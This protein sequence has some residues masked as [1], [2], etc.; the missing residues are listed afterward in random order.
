M[1]TDFKKRFKHNSWLNPPWA[2]ITAYRGSIAHGMYVPQSDP[3]SIDDKDVMA[4]V[5]PDQTH[6]FGLTTFGSKGTME[7]KE[8]EWDIVV[9]ELRKFVGLLVK[10]NPNVITMLWLE[11]QDYIN[12]TEAGEVLIK[13]R[14]LFSTRQ[15]FHSF[16]GYAKGQLHR[17]THMAFEGYMGEKR[18]RLVKQFGY[19]TK[20]AA[21][22]IRLLRMSIEFLTEGRMYVKRKDAQELLA[23][24]R[25]EWSL[26]KVKEE[27]TRLFALSEEAYVRSPLPDRPDM[28]MV[29][30]ICT[31]AAKKALGFKL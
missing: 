15:A 26:E 19:D 31:L 25:G 5:V 28:D 22:L 30:G 12:V 1:A 14:D 20:N 21:H 27:S 13:N 6:Y 16:S 24:K 23:I 18:K 17:M 4:I 8:D 2:I 29:N 10:A 7:I 11:D 3:N 9:Y